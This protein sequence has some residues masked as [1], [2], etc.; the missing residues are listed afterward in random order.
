M[1]VMGY[2]GERE[3]ERLLIGMHGLEVDGPW[4]S[5]H[6][7]VSS[8][9]A[10]LLKNLVIMSAC[11]HVAFAN[12][13]PCELGKRVPFAGTVIIDPRLLLPTSPV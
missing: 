12:F 6:L 4:D 11:V 5:S 1:D 7:K 8:D 3:V 13:V 10:A 2:V 9:S